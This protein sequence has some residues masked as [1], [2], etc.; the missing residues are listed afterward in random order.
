MR[1]DRAVQTGGRIDDGQA[2]AIL[3]LQAFG[4]GFVRHGGISSQ[5]WTAEEGNAGRHGPKAVP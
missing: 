1:A 4:D 3:D 2:A 5:S